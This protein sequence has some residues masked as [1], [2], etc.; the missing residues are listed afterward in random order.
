VPGLIH[1]GVVGETI[2]V[3]CVSF[4]QAVW[5]IIIINFIYYRGFL[6]LIGEVSY[7]FCPVLVRCRATEK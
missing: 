7:Y 5:C 3:F 1:I 6:L 4:T 2:A